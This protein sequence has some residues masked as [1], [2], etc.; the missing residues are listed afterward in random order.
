MNILKLAFDVLLKLVRPLVTF[1][2]LLQIEKAKH[3]ALRKENAERNN[4]SPEG[5]KERE[6]D[7]IAQA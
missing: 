7:K 3:Q 5:T 1:F 2:Y 6:T 4:L